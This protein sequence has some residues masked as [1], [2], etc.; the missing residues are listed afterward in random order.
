M[1]FAP[2]Y[3]NTT[4]KAKSNGIVSIKIVLKK[5][6]HYKIDRKIKANFKASNVA[7]TSFIYQTLSFEV[8]LQKKN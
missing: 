7:S 5:S 6:I 3:A 2:I 1:A 4:T 8:K